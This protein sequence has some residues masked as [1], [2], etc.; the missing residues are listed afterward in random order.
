MKIAYVCPQY[1]PYLGGV[2]KY[3]HAIATRLGDHH[4]VSVITTDPSGKLP[5]CER[6]DSVWIRRFPSWAFSESVYHSTEMFRYLRKHSDDY[7]LVHANNYHA[8]PA[9]YAAESKA[10]NRLVFTPHFHG[11]KGH[12]PMRNLFHIPYRLL[13]WRIFRRSDRIICSTY[14]EGNKILRDFRIPKY[15]LIMIRHG[16][17]QTP[18][19]PADKSSERKTLLCVSRLERYKGIQHVIT[20]L[21]YLPPF[22]LVVVG[23]GPYGDTLRRLT[24]ELGFEERVVFKQGVSEENLRRL[25]G[26]SD[27]AILLSEHESYSQFIAEALS[28]GIP[29]V[30]AKRDALLEWIDGNTC[31]GVDD[32]ADAIDVAHA[33]LRLVGRKVTRTLPTWDD[34]VTELE[35][36]YRALVD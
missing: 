1:P 27:V 12:S 36:L 32:P 10:R 24:E 35:A 16:V 15:K 13:G 20:A 23:A 11:A 18:H 34:Y 17:E 3:V 7:D 5:K 9:Y 33:V 30:L 22:H 25:Y 21:K 31:V 29:C 6:I 2:E 19:V 26:N 28:A 14:F 4:D 8:L